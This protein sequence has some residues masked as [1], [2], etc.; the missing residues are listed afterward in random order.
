[1]ADQTAK[2]TEEIGQ[3]VTEIQ[4]ATNSA[5]SAIE[6]IGGTIRTV[7][8]IASSIAAAVEEQGAATQ[9]IATNV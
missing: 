5:V 4:N 1:L 7:D 3:Q 2:A 9:E 6:A 8:D